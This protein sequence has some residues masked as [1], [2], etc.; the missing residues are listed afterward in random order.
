MVNRNLLKKHIV[1]P[2]EIKKREIDANIFLATSLVKRGYKVYISNKQRINSNLDKL[3]KSIFILKSLSPKNYRYLKKIK[4]FGHKICCLDVEGTSYLNLQMLKKRASNLNLDLVEYFFCWGKKM[5]IDMIKLFPKYK[6]KFIITGHPRIEILKDLNSKIYKKES[7]IIK[8]KFGQFIL[9][10][11]FFNNYNYYDK[12]KNK[13]E[14][15]KSHNN[16][17]SIGK[18]LQRHQRENF[19]Q[20]FKLVDDLNKNLPNQK[21]IIRPHPV[22]NIDI[23]NEYFKN[24]KNVKIITDKQSTCSWII[25]SQMMVSCNCTTLAESYFLK[26]ISINFMPFK[27][28]RVLYDLP[29]NCSYLVKNLKELMYL[30]RSKKYR[31]LK[32][33]SSQIEKTSKIIYNYNKK[34]SNL[35]IF[36]NLE[37]IKLDSEQIKYS[38]QK[39]LIKKVL[40]KIVKLKLS[41]LKNK[42]QKIIDHKVGLLK[43][44]E[45]LKKINQ[46]K[47]SKNIKVNEFLPEIFSLS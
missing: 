2:Y 21:I 36:N 27:D 16:L 5:K 13:D 22:E 35:E 26:K 41:Y 10:T 46:F 19:Y 39:I 40:R 44:N 9:I 34:N 6:N 24:K 23:W 11:T 47:G 45:V 42:N 33:K 37:N 32:L 3:P 17:T 30:I 12:T 8:K 25:A 20:F 31:N 1:I 18:L 38:P 14:I 15:L 43:K 4:S 28:K 29:L 7:K